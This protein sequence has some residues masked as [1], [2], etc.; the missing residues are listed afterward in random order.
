MSSSAAGVDQLVKLV[1]GFSLSEAAAKYANCYP[2]RNPFDLY[3]A[4]LTD[5]LTA[6]TGVDAKIVYPALQWT[7]GLDKGDLILAVPALRVKGKKPDELA[8]EWVEKVRLRAS[9]PSGATPDKAACP[10]S[11]V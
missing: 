3:R 5:V 10:D 2:D 8:K 1:D 9:N 4:H 11:P 6:V 7:T